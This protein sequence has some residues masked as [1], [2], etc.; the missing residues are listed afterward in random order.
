MMRFYISA[1]V[2]GLA[3]TVLVFGF[4]GDAVGIDTMVLAFAVLVISGVFAWAHFD[5]RAVA[6]GTADDSGFHGETSRDDSAVYH[7]LQAG[8]ATEFDLCKND[9]FHHQGP[10]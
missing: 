3:A 4:M 1:L 10:Q 5:G 6:G 2:A 7:S 9:P 8:R